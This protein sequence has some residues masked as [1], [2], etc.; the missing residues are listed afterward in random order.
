M[1]KN[2][3]I[4]LQKFISCSLFFTEH[5]DKHDECYICEKKTNELQYDSDFDE[6]KCN[7]CTQIEEMNYTNECICGQLD[8]LQYES[9]QNMYICRPCIREEEM[10]KQCCICLQK[11]EE[12][13]YD[14]EEEDYM[15]RICIKGG[16]QTHGYNSEESVSDS[17]DDEC[18]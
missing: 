4:I 15:C 1:H 7:I 14:P 9:E 12:L 17:E 6:Y 11:P 8:E 2:C 16:Q 5:D 13:L 18:V 10:P 3:Y